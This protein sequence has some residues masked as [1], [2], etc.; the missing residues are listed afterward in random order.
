MSRQ[1]SDSSLSSRASQLP[2][3]IMSTVK[4]ATFETIRARWEEASH[5]AQ[6]E[7]RILRKSE[8]FLSVSLLSQPLNHLTTRAFARRRTK[9]MPT[10]ITPAFESAVTP[11]ELSEN[12]TLLPQ[13][14]H[15]D[16]PVMSKNSAADSLLPIRSKPHFISSRGHWNDKNYITGP[17]ES[18]QIPF[19]RSGQCITQNPLRPCPKA[20]LQHSNSY[21]EPG[22]QHCAIPTPTNAKSSI[23]YSLRDNASRTSDNDST[24]L[25]ILP[26]SLTLPSVPNVLNRG[27]PLRLPSGWDH[28]SPVRYERSCSDFN[29][30][31]MAMNVP[32]RSTQLELTSKGSTS[33]KQH[34]IEPGAYV[35]NKFSPKAFHRPVSNHQGIVPSGSTHE[36]TRRGFVKSSP[37]QIPHTISCRGPA[38]RYE[39]TISS[40]ERITP[41]LCTKDFTKSSWNCHT[42]KPLP[43]QTRSNVI[44]Y[45]NI[46]PAKHI[47]IKSY[48][49][50]TRT[51]LAKI[52]PPLSELSASQ[53]RLI[54]S[55]SHHNRL[56]L[57]ESSNLSSKAKSNNILRN[58]L[59]RFFSSYDVSRKRLTN[60]LSS[61]HIGRSAS[62]LGDLGSISNKPHTQKH[63]ILSTQTSDVSNQS[64]AIH[65]YRGIPEREL[66]NQSRPSNHPFHLIGEVSQVSQ[67]MPRSYWAGRLSSTLDSIKIEDRPNGS[68]SG[69]SIA[70]STSPTII[71]GLRHL[72]AANYIP[73]KNQRPGNQLSHD[74]L[75]LRRAFEILKSYCQNN[76][77]KASLRDFMHGYANVSKMM[78]LMAYTPVLDLSGN[79]HSL[80]RE[81]ALGSPERS[82]QEQGAQYGISLPDN[83]STIDLPI[84]TKSRRS[85]LMERLV[86]KGRKISQS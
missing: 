21:T 38:N 18:T 61:L 16:A 43:L 17:D 57:F 62:S 72:S 19:P 79:S 14:G 8:K 47:S 70:L 9:T 4:S 36:H 3:A 10:L 76:A 11:I 15:T 77:A 75:Q 27:S 26:R 24:T 12:Q 56:A 30:S 60:P 1:A 54:S 13:T 83:F 66:L 7:D 53:P 37:P 71:H 55:S 52:T 85:S 82:S 5:I 59:S 64:S 78:W 73:S 68:T 58:P 25:K 33:S 34:L 20:S 28:K 80:R 74:E 67:A 6:E 22:L 65:G 51:S 48:A 45:E 29:S 84:S 35:R 42:S 63:D 2:H 86:V 81:Q 39:S 32:T 31:N 49:S 50:P 41:D 23:F 69:T 40:T 44:T 46:H